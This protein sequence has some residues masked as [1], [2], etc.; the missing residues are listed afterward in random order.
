MHCIRQPRIRILSLSG[1]PCLPCFG[2]TVRFSRRCQPFPSVNRASNLKREVRLFSSSTT[3]RGFVCSR[4]RS[5]SHP[6]P[7]PHSPLAT[8]LGAVRVRYLLQLACPNYPLA[9]VVVFPSESYC[10]LGHTKETTFRSVWAGSDTTVLSKPPV[11][12]FVTLAGEVFIVADALL[13]ASCACAYTTNYITPQQFAA[14]YRTASARYITS[15]R[16]YARTHARTPASQPQP[17]IATS[18]YAGD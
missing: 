17:G 18:Y 10:R 9:T 11:I 1:E 7:H 12:F 16:T 14:P 15:P 5:R 4:P 8:L 3:Y 2:H 6:C 13:G